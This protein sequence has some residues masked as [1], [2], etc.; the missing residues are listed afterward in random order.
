M[1]EEKKVVKKAVE[2]AEKVADPV[3]ATIDPASQQMIRRAQE[4]KIDTCFDRAVKM[5]PCNIGATGIC[6]KNCGMGP[7]RLTL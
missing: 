4:L 7:C 5:K 3:A 2:K 1:S 6:C